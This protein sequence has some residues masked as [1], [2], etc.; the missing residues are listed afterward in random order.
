M[1]KIK[2]FTFN[3][4]GI[5]TYVIWNPETGSCAVIDPGMINGKEQAEID[6]FISKEG[7][8]VNNL[9]NTHMHVDHIFGDLYIKEKYG[10]DIAACKDDSFLGERSAT[11][12][13]M[14]GLPDDMT[15][16]GID[17]ELADGD[18]VDI[19]GEQVKVLAVPGHSPGSIVLYFP[20]SKWAVT[21]DVL[22]RR[23]VGRT[24]LVAGNHS[25]LI[26]GI[27]KKLF[28]LPDDVKVYPGHGEPTTIGEE[29]RE[30]PFVV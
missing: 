12:C 19:G 13:R 11:Q 15:A 16:V 24:D 2:Q 3:M 8:V 26:D 17:R 20:D 30:N 9:I 1:L 21:G 14:F 23:S 5:N 25:Q 6:G 10:V 7:L 28:S 4:F 27:K 22:F 18:T 29:K